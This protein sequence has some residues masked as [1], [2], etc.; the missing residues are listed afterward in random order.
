MQTEITIHGL[1]PHVLALSHFEWV[2]FTPIFIMIFNA[3]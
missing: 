1:D 2:R 3:Y